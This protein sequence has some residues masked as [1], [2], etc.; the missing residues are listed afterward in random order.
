MHTHTNIRAT[1]H[2]SLPAHTLTSVHP[3]L[4]PFILTSFSCS[5]SKVHTLEDY[6]KKAHSLMNYCTAPP[7]RD[8]AQL[9]S[10]YVILYL[11][12]SEGQI[13]IILTAS[14]GQYNYPGS[15]GNLLFKNWLCFSSRACQRMAPSDRV[16]GWDSTHLIQTH[17]QLFNA[18]DEINFWH[19]TFAQISRILAQL[20]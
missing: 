9:T 14:K 19:S 16:T 8:L 3:P 11:W 1:G 17:T 15:P 4:L 18:V 7:H 2:L 12:T 6:N 13:K 5:T 20:R 10:L